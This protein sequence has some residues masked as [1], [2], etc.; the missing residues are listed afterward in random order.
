MIERNIKPSFIFFVALVIALIFLNQIAHF[1]GEI[2]EGFYNRDAIIASIIILI[3]VFFSYYYWPKIRTNY[4]SD[5]RITLGLF[6]IG[7]IYLFLRFT[8]SGLIL[9]PYD[10]FFKYSDVILYPVVLHLV[11]LAKTFFKEYKINSGLQT[12][13]KKS[14]FLQDSLHTSGEI[15]NEKILLKLQD[16]VQNFK[17]EHSFSI[18]I[19]AVWGYGKSSFLKKFE[20]NYSELNGDAVIFWN[21]IWKNK[22]ANAIIENFFQE[23][24]ENLSPY[25]SSISS[26]IDNY[27]EAILSI[28]PNDFS[29]YIK[30]GISI[31]SENETLERHFQEINRNIQVIDR[32]IIVLLDDLD[33]LERDEI[34]STLKIIRTIS[35]FSHVIFIAGYDRDYIVQTLKI[36]KNNFL[37]KIFNVEINLLPFDE[38]L[39]SDE[40]L[41]YV[42]EAYPI[43]N[44]NTDVNG[45][46]AGFRNI[47]GEIQDN[48]EVDLTIADLVEEDN[49]VEQPL[50]YNDFLQTYR[51]VK[52]FFN[53]FK[54]NASFL[55][56]E[57]DVI[58][59][60]YI[61]LKLLFYKFRNLQ[62]I[63]IPKL[64]FLLSK[65]T[66][67]T[68]NNKVQQFGGASLSNVYMFDSDAK[69]KI[70]ELLKTQNFSESDL[71]I[72]NSVLCRLFK[73]RT[74]DYYNS[75]INSIS[76]I[77]FTDMY[78]R[79]NIVGGKVSIT[80]LQN[81][82]KE[83]KL[84][85][86]SKSI[87]NNVN[88]AQFQ[89]SN[90]IK[91]FIFSNPPVKLDQFLDQ[92]RSLN[93]LVHTNTFSDDQSTINL[94][95]EA[96]HAFYNKEKTSLIPDL[97]KVVNNESSGYLIRLFREVNLNLIRD[98]SNMHYSNK[99]TY[100]NLELDS[101]DLKEILISKLKHLISNQGDPVE[102][103]N[104]YSQHVEFLALDKQILRSQKGNELIKKDIEKRFVKYFKSSVFKSLKGEIDDNEGEFVGYSPNFSFA[105]IFSNPKTLEALQLDP[106]DK[107]IYDRFYKEGWENFKEF[108]LTINKK[109]F[110]ET[111]VDWEGVE[112]M[113]KFIYVYVENNCE[114][115]NKDRYEK[116]YS[117]LPF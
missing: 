111:D 26:N 57:E 12:E 59:E 97:I 84:Y 117:E 58:A 68:E 69:G 78:L 99:K 30:S 49:C 36:E 7:I 71:S 63:L 102:I 73:K 108:I 4:L 31:F 37:D 64:P 74:P 20:K 16:S 82:F 44:N 38:T 103:F 86:I 70:N 5:R 19:N 109:D 28:S 53:E 23:L 85:A 2:G 76:K 35:D 48:K 42:N 21:H 66:I 67:D 18:G 81:G 61:L 14:Y 100:A 25:S 77:Y 41:T 90:E 113:K 72:I 24:K 62:S 87:S 60:E 43:S 1:I 91:Q 93:F 51:D 116:I 56:N 47:F 115:L 29:K 92:L 112:K 46:N 52:R 10:S 104:T 39:I 98:N 94:I 83:A 110:K 106:Q 32:Q 96:Y 11:V 75:N 88:Q 6:L 13:G 50:R 8:D 27:V 54:F 15:D 22:G 79:N 9:K 80:D 40:L 45:F 34:I 65:G 33:R 17:P 101:T 114:P 95:R 89:I 3:I 55:D 107:V 105:Q